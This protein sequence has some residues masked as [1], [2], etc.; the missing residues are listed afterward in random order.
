MADTAIWNFKQLGHHELDGFGGIGEG[1]SIQIAKDG[2]RILQ[3]PLSY[4]YL[5]E[6]RVNQPEVWRSS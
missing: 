3:P 5:P 1:M 2:R 4:Q 6:H